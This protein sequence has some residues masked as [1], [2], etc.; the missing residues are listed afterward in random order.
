MEISPGSS[1]RRPVVARCRQHDPAGA[2]ASAEEGRTISS[3][4]AAQFGSN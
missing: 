3:Y 2:P 1:E 4:L